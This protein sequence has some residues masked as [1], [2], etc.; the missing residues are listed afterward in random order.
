[1][2]DA[3]CRRWFCFRI[4]AIAVLAAL[5]VALDGLNDRLSRREE[6]QLWL[7]NDAQQRWKQARDEN[8]LQDIR[9][10]HVSLLMREQQLR[11][12]RGLKRNGATLPINWCGTGEGAF[13]RTYSVL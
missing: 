7:K 12:E 1:M 4:W 6:R 3:S 13:G 5:L 2:A 10:L 8:V 9:K 11:Y